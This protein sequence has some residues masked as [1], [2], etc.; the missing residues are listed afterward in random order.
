MLFPLSFHITSKVFPYYGDQ[1]H[2]KY[3]YSWAYL[4]D[5][6]AIFSSLSSAPCYSMLDSLDQRGRT[7]GPREPHQVR[8]QL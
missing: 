2:V 6:V 7:G 3:L 4:L 8:G 1:R 5:G